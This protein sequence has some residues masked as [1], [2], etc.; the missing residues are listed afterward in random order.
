M[1][2]TICDTTVQKMRQLGLTPGRLITIEQR[3]PR[4]IVRVGNDR[5]ALDDRVINSIYVRVLEH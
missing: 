3:F 2:P 4:F 1:R 5:H